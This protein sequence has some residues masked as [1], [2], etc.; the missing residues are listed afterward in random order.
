MPKIEIKTF[1]NAPIEIC[2][3]LSTSIDLHKIS[4]V[5]TNENAIY[6]VTTGLIK[7]NETVTWQATH[8]GIKQQLTSKIIEYNRPYNFTD[9]QIKGIFKSF[10][11]QHL[12]EEVD[13]RVLMKDIFDFESPFGFVGHIFNKIILTKYL[14]K[15]LIER[16]NTIKEYAET[17]KWKL[18]C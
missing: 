15:F 16:N 18:I 5:K 12:F 4:T 11:H 10:Y 7:L 17:D 2:F 14:K 1:I 8:F 3:D 13:D 6:G 9:V